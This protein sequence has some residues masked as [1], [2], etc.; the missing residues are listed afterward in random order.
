[1]K[2]ISLVLC[3]LMANLT[4]IFLDEGKLMNLTGNISNTKDTKIVLSKA[5]MEIGWIPIDSTEIHEGKFNFDIQLP[6][7]SKYLFTLKPSGKRFKAILENGTISITGDANKTY[8]NYLEVEVKGSYNDSLRTAFSNIL[9]SVYDQEKYAAYNMLEKE[10]RNEKDA[11][12]K[13]EMKQQM[14]PYL[15]KITSEIIN[16][17]LDFVKQ[18]N[19]T[20][21]AA[22]LIHDIKSFVS[23]EELRSIFNGFPEK[24]Q[25]APV[26]ANVKMKIKNYE[27]VLPGKTA[28]DFTLKNTEGENVSL[29]SYRGKIVLLDFWASWC[30]PCRASFPHLIELYNKYKHKGFEILGVSTDS[31]QDLW[32][33]AIKKDGI[34]WVQTIDEYPEKRKPSKISTMYAV[35]KIPATVLID[36]DGKIIGNFKAKELDEKTGRTI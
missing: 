10:Y 7:T 12:K 29:S 28:P 16:R 14:A 36:R 32:K 20:Y 18:H 27:N 17:Q 5:S 11:E 9:N 2:N 34:M 3:L 22:T 24:L 30:A 33:K 6:D 4:A 19:N 35:Y 31:K 21:A 1:M 15:V 25:N 26:L 23:M 8:R 13:K